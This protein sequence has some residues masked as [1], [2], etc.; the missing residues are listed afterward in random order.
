MKRPYRF[1]GPPKP[2]LPNRLSGTPIP[3]PLYR[4]PPVQD[5]E[6]LPMRVRGDG[7]AVLIEINGSTRY[8]TGSREEVKR[9]LHDLE[10]GLRQS[11]TRLGT[12]DGVNPTVARPILDS[13]VQDLN[14]LPDAKRRQYDCVAKFSEY[15]K[16]C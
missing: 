2:R 7:L 10:Q 3:R 5:P 11:S 9:S 1:T 13:M 15:A 4:V 12:F 8:I 6:R 14:A 16:Q